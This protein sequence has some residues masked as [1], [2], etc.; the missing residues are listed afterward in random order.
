MTPLLLSIFGGLGAT[1]RFITDGII[2][3]KLGKRFPW[4]T[5]L[6]NAVG[7]GILGYITARTAMHG[8]TLS[9]KLVIGVGFCGGFT[10]FST[11]C[12]E[13]VRLAEEKRYIAFWLQVTGN[14]VLSLAAIYVGMFIA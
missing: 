9:T 12:F 1:S 6:I 4:A 13:A 2:S 11:A 8:L 14:L 3:A 7:A 5:M 10:T